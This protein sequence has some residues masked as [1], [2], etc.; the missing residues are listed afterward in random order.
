MQCSTLL[1]NNST[2]MYGCK[3]WCF[4]KTSILYNISNQNYNAPFY[5]SKKPYTLK[6]TTWLTKSKP[7]SE[8]CRYNCT[9]QK[10]LM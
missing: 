8:S 2:Y 6:Q 10:S 4:I 1:D 3:V 7:N 5:V 9:T